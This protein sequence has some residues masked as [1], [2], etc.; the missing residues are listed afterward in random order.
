MTAI[1]VNPDYRAAT[2]SREPPSLQQLVEDAGGFN[3]I[4]ADQWAE[5]DARMALWKEFVRNGGLH[6]Q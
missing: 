2:D 6:R 1:P 3:R 4:T 5:F